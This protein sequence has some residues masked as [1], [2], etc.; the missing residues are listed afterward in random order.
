M[1]F[2]LNDARNNLLYFQCVIEDSFQT[3]ASIRYVYYIN[4]YKIR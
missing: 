4:N 2:Q 3:N 1:Y